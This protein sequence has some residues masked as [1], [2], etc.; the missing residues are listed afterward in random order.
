MHRKIAQYTGILLLGLALLACSSPEEKA[1]EYIASGNL[2]FDAGEY[3]KAEVEYRNALQINQNL[4]D[5]WY[6]LARIYE[7]K[8]DWRKAY[9]VLNKI[10]ELDPSHVDGR[11]MLAQMLLASNQIDQALTDATEILELAPDNPRA[12]A[13][14]A[15]IQFRLENHAGA[16]AEVD[17]AL[18]VDPDNQDAILVRSRVLIADQKYAEAHSLLDSAIGKNPEN[19][20]LHLM[21]IQAYQEQGDKAA[22][23]QSYLQLVR[24][25]PDNK[26]FSYALAQLYARHE[27]LDEAEQVM[28]QI[29]RSNPADVED[30]VR[31][32][33]FKMQHRS[34]DEAIGLTKSYIESDPSTFRFRFLLGELYENSGQAG[35]ARRLYQAIVDEDGLNANGIEARNKIALIELRGGNRDRARQLVDEVLAHDNANENAL[36]LRAGIQIDDRNFDD[37]VIN[38]R[39]VLRDNPESVKALFLLGQAY[40]ATGS[41][42]L[43]LESYT[44]AFNLKPGAPLTANAL[45]D[46]LFRQRKFEQTD[47][48]L[49]RSLSSGN[50]SVDAIKLLAQVKLALGEWDR[51]EKLAQALRSI[52]GQEAMSEQVMGAVFQGRDQR[53]DSIEAFKRAHELAPDAL[54]PMVALVRTY[55]RNGQNPEAR[56]F[57]D[58]VV[59]DNPDNTLAYMLLG[60]LSLLENDPG[61]AVAQF[62]K[63]IE[64]AP[65]LDIGYRGLASAY[66]SAGQFDK[67]GESIRRGLDAIPNLPVLNMTL[68]SIYEVQGRFDEAMLIYESLLEQKPDQL[69]A[70]NNLAS[71][72]TD[73]RDDQASL[74]RARTMAAEFKDSRIPQFRDTYA[75]AA[76]RSGINLEEAV[77]I[78][79][80][81][82]RDND[83]VGVYKY[84][85][86]EA[87]RKKGDSENALAMLKQAAEQVTPGSDIADKIGAALEQID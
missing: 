11:I 26:N 74:D 61:G 3:F 36:L 64:I 71:L 62:N 69:I 14:M 12:H 16:Q 63:V 72:L 80:R 30:K 76:V 51:A 29:V 87:Y 17:K 79:E 7:R 2:R 66:R 57:L 68:A 32:V 28:S 77:V 1:A 67:A 46:T 5:A 52:K 82:V 55:L 4:S 83:S 73:N 39:T 9:A 44:K 42:E 35:E 37:A 6:G 13:L 25:F 27:K 18:A 70:K 81:I 75:W 10:R 47:E 43:A 19:V 50:R 40:A 31:L 60:Q 38:L 45:A 85:L 54:Q 15:A 48:V 49:Q 58:S 33:E 65:D 23:E 41:T 59:E 56:K 86:G 20:S 53:E 34:L 24:L 8:Q 22:I 78:L 21:K 84:H